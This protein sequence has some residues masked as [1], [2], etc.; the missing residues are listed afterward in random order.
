VRKA[1][2]KREEGK[3]AAGAPKMNVYR[4]QQLRELLEV[5]K[6]T[7]AKLSVS[8]V[9]ALLMWQETPADD[10][11]RLVATLDIDQRVTALRNAAHQ[12]GPEAA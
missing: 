3:A 8:Q 9:E 4:E 2:R 7:E 5:S 10:V 6:R 12:H 1:W 11:R